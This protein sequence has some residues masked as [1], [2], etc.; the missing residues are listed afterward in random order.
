MRAAV[1]LHERRRPPAACSVTSNHGVVQVGVDLLADRG[2]VV[3][4][5]AGPIAATWRNQKL[6]KESSMW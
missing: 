5:A 6:E 1:L 3:P 4:F 2:D